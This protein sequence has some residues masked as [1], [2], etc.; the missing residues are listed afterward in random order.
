MSRLGSSIAAAVAVT[1]CAGG[2]LL[3][4]PSRAALV[5][6]LWLVVVLALALGVALQH[7]RRAVPRSPSAFDAAFSPAPRAGAR[8]A[9]LA[10]L[11]RT[12]TLATGTAFDVHYRLR[13]VL[14][15]VASDVL[16]RRGVNPE[17]N[18]ARAQSLLGPTVWEL[19]RPDRPAP[20]DRAA[21]GLPV[22]T[23]ER[24]VD[25]LERLA[26]S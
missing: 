26:C 8:P 15:A 25:D 4:V 2:V 22:A 3:A 13:P 10:R 18:P 21:P 17:R 6:H 11:E 7:L 24:A 9:A 5:A 16:A 23:I 12:V 14:V 19:V 20:S 1:I